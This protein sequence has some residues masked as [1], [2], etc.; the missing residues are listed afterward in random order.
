MSL[1]NRWSLIN[2]SCTALVGFQQFEVIDN[3][4]FTSGKNF[5]AFFRES[6]ISIR[7]ICNNSYRTVRESNCDCNIVAFATVLPLSDND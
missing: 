4:R 5:N 3:C 2:F 7:E 6:G 1:F